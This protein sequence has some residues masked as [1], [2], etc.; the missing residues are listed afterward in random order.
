MILHLNRFCDHRLVGTFGELH[1]P[2][3]GEHLGYTVE[4]PW[5][6]NSLYKAGQ[7][8][9]SCVPAGSY[10]LIPFHSPKWGSVYALRNHEL[11]VMVNKQD[12]QDIWHRWACLFA[13]KGNFASDFEGCIGVGKSLS[14]IE[15]IWC[16]T[17][18]TNTVKKVMEL[19][20]N[21][22]D[23]HQLVIT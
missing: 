21:N 8:F 4:K 6:V 22:A 5:M 11:G 17:D 10:D 14:A 16:V 18:T 7:P 20:K 23:P 13:H 3:T 9:N 15:G 19:L 1:V 12:R 2:S